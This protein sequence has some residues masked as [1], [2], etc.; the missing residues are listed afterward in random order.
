[1]SY[2]KVT[3]KTKNMLNNLSAHQLYV[4]NIVKSM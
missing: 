3:E 2:V 4:E 1:M